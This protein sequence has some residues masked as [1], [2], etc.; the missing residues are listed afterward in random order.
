MG[1]GGCP[2]LDPALPSSAMATWINLLPEYRN[3]C[4]LGPGPQQP[5][6]R[7]RHNALPDNPGQTWADN[8]PVL[9]RELKSEAGKLSGTDLSSRQPS[10]W[11]NSCLHLFFLPAEQFLLLSLPLKWLPRQRCRSS[12]LVHGL[13]SISGAN[14]EYLIGTVWVRSPY[15]E[16][17]A[18]SPGDGLSQGLYN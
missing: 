6:H 9:A 15:L 4:V 5:L 10:K 8:G 14:W 7:N 17:S 12:H 13:N 1:P 3:T 11:P 16:Q 2:A 18:V